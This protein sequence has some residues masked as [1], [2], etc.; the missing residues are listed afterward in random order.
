MQ[1]YAD[2]HSS[3]AHTSAPRPW[4]SDCSA[5]PFAQLE[6]AIAALEDDLE[7]ARSRDDARKVKEIETA[8]AAR[9]SWLEQVVKAAADSRG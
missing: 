6:S 3:V 5:L 2:C 8:L 4:V 7:K 1:G 9:R